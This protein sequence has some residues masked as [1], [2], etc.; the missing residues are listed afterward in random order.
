[1]STKQHITD[2][3]VKT[4]GAPSTVNP[5][6]Q[7]IARGQ[8]VA[9][10]LVKSVQEQGEKLKRFLMD[11]VNLSQA[12]RSGFRV[13]VSKHLR[14]IRK[15]VDATKGTPEHAAYAAASR[16]AGVRLSEAVTFSKAVDAG[17]SPDFN[18]IPYHSMI[19]A[20]RTML[21]SES[22]VGPTQ[23][24][25]RKAASPVDKAVAY[26]AKLG[27]KRSDLL[28]VEHVVHELA[29]GKIK[30]DAIL[31]PAEPAKPAAVSNIIAMPKANST[32]KG[33]LAEERAAAAKGQE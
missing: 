33:T 27:L 13:A 18:G 17:F 29:T 9:A 2:N 4:T 31:K 22:A 8:A 20:A 12:G 15:H 5:D 28:K 26:I 21:D 1:M 19:G 11:I 30:P 23:K 7:D 16:S 25:G 6:L 3:P 14:D 10:L 32:S 24:R